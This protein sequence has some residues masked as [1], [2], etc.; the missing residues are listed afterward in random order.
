MISDDVG[1]SDYARS[2]RFDVFNLPFQGVIVDR[3]DD[4]N[5]VLVADG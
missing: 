4:A 3:V 2:T 5:M 1:V